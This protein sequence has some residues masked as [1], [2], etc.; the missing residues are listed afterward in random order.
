MTEETT[1]ETT[2]ATTISS[3]SLSL[4]GHAGQESLDNFPGERS[5]RMVLEMSCQGSQCKSLSDHPDKVIAVRYWYVHPVEIVGDTG[6]VD[7]A[8]RIV[9]VTPSGYYYQC[10]STGVAKVIAMITKYYGR[11]VLDPPVYFKVVKQKG[12]RGTFMTLDLVDH[13][14]KEFTVDLP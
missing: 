11:E 1:Q 4:L 10:V 14:V 8:V 5:Q 3:N 12:R 2:I 13:T 7:E 9:L 6:E